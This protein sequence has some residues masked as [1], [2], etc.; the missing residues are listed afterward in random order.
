[1]RDHADR[2]LSRRSPVEPWSKPLTGQAP[3]PA[4]TGINR[5]R[6]VLQ[7][8]RPL[9]PALVRALADQLEDHYRRNGLQKKWREG[10]PLRLEIWLV[11]PMLTIG[12][13]S[14]LP[15][16]LERLWAPI[17]EG[18]IAALFLS[19]QGKPLS[20]ASGR[21]ARSRGAGGRVRHPGHPGRDCP[22]PCGVD[23]AAVHG[24]A[25]KHQHAHWLAKALRTPH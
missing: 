13:G 21:R 18:A 14:S 22:H 10:S 24:R 17:F 7:P 5:G 8:S 4:K 20:G 2:P 6:D 3:P 12:Q 16:R 23:S 25:R 9:N 11:E 1:M 15:S 19:H